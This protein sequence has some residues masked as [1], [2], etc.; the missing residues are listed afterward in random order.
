MMMMMTEVPGSQTKSADSVRSGRVRSGACSGIQLEPTTSGH[1]AEFEGDLRICREAPDC[2][3]V[4][5][6]IAT[7]VASRQHASV[8]EHAVVGE[9]MVVRHLQG[10]R[11]ALSAAR[12]HRPLPGVAATVRCRVAVPVSCTPPQTQLHGDS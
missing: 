10:P 12:R 5:G 9:E 2:S 3:V 7:V 11:L 1:F 6:R 4:V 8:R